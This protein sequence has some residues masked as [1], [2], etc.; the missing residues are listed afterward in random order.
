M[1]EGYITIIDHPI[2]HAQFVHN[3]PVTN[4]HTNWDG[5]ADMNTSNAVCTNDHVWA[6]AGG[7]LEGKTCLCGR[8]IY[9]KVICT[10]CGDPFLIAVK[11]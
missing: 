11:K 2:G 1:K 10:N 8:M 6:T 5:K 9:K 7:D 3:I 4:S